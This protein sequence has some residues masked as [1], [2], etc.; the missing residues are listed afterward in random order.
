MSAGKMGQ[1]EQAFDRQTCKVDFDT[2]DH[3]TD[4]GAIR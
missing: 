1:A 4:F 2:T 3:L